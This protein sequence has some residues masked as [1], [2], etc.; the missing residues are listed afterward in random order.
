MRRSCPDL[1]DVFRSSQ[2][3]VV[4]AVSPW[5]EDHAR[6]RAILDQTRWLYHSVPACGEAF[7]FLRGLSPPV[8]VCERS[9]PDGTWR[10]LLER[11]AGL[12]SPP[13]MIVTAAD[14]DE[15]LW[16]EV[17]NT[18]GYDVLAKP[19]DPSEVTRIIGLAW[20]KWSQAARASG[21][22]RKRPAAGLAGGAAG[23]G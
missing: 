23:A 18:G 12:E 4:L 10:D 9:L 7:E 15:T 16:A 3:A 8:V 6:L 21:A 1:P 2:T 13:Q 14:A 22:Q 5:E 17:L 19:F 20:L 11:V